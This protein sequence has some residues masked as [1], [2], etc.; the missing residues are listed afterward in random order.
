MPST[1]KTVVKTKI[2]LNVKVLLNLENQ[3]FLFLTQEDNICYN[4]SFKKTKN[5]NIPFPVQYLFFWTF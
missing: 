5:K 4:F 1:I 2:L 3:Q